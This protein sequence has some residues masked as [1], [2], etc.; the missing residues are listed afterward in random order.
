M[1]SHIHKSVTK[2]SSIKGLVK[3]FS[4]I[5]SRNTIQTY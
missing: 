1:I 2:E 5:N 4:V 3:T